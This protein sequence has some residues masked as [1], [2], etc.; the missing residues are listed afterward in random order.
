VDGA[1]IVVAQK[2]THV[3]ADTGGLQLVE[4]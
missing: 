3:G 4:I 2:R 1:N